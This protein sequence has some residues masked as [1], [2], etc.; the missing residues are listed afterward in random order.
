[1]AH[2]LVQLLTNVVIPTTTSMAITSANKAM[3]SAL[4][5][6]TSPSIQKQKKQ[7]GYNISQIKKT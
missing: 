5:V 6:T 3:A 2:I 4:M 7:Q 1:M